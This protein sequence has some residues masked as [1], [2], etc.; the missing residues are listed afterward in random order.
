MKSI[1]ITIHI[2]L[3]S[4][5]AI[6]QTQPQSRWANPRYLETLPCKQVTDMLQDKDGFLWIATRNG[7]FRY[8][9][10]SL[11]PYRNDLRNVQYLSGNNIKCIAEQDQYIWIA[12]TAGLDR[13]SKSTSQSPTPAL[14]RREGESPA[15]TLSPSPA[16]PRREG[17][18]TGVELPEVA[19]MLVS[20]RG[21][22]WL[23]TEDGVFAYNPK[24]SNHFVPYDSA[25]TEGVIPT[26]LNAKCLLEDHLGHI[27]VGSW[28]QGLYRIDADHQLYYHYPDFNAGHNAHVLVE[29]NHKQIWIGTWGYGVE[30]LQNAWEPAITTARHYTTQ[31]G[32]SGNIIY[33]LSNDSENDII[34]VGTQRGL[35]EINETAFGLRNEAEASTKRPSAY[36]TAPSAYETLRYENKTT[37]QHIITSTQTPFNEI[38]CLLKDRQNQYWVGMMGLGAAHVNMQS[39]SFTL[40]RLPE[41]QKAINTADVRSLLV[42]H[43]GTL[44]LSVGTAG[45]GTIASDGRFTPWWNMPM[46]KGEPTMAT[47]YSLM[48]RSTDHHL[49]FATYG[50]YLY[51]VDVD[52]RR[53]TRH[54]PQTLRCM[55]RQHVNVISED[56]HG[57]LWFGGAGG[58][59]ILRTDGSQLLLDTLH[60][61]PQLTTGQ[62]E[63]RDII[64]D[65][66]NNTW[67]ATSKDGLFRLYAGRDGR[68][69]SDAFTRQNGRLLSASLQCLYSDSQGNIW[70]GTDNCG[71]FRY[72]YTTATFE[73]LNNRWSLPCV[74]V[75]SIIEEPAS[76]QDLPGR[77]H[78][79]LGTDNGLVLLDVASDAQSASVYHYTPDDGL[80]DYTFNAGSVTFDRATDEIFFGGLKGYNSFLPKEVQHDASQL[81]L[82][83]T[84][85]LVNDQSLDAHPD[86]HITL[87]HQQNNFALQFTA[88]DLV[89]PQRQSYI[90]QLQGY[91]TLWHYTDA[92][93]RRAHYSA[94]PAGTYTF[95]CQLSNSPESRTQLQI[96]ILPAP[97]RTWWAYTA[98][99]LF[100]L[101]VIAWII[102]YVRRKQTIQRS[103]RQRVHERQRQIELL[104]QQARQQQEANQLLLARNTMHEETQIVALPDADQQFLSRAIA[105]VNAHLS[106]ADF[107]QQQFLDEMGISKTTCFRRLKTLTGYSFP[108]FVRNIRMDAAAQALQANPTLRISEL[109]YSVGYTDAGYF[110]ACFRKEFGVLPTDYAKNL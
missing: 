55:P 30:C 39:S 63:V 27:W 33:S 52:A 3:L 97:W 32:L 40:N 66:Y 37:K 103:L 70:L 85:L 29:D 86:G 108:N 4:L 65:R 54:T 64:E 6:A 89:N 42:D 69:H 31:Q 11:T 15:Q 58:L 78:L 20:R 88:L 57:C 110:S 87:T 34:L 73:S 48:Q 67:I 82:H 68:W 62:V 9:G 2:F 10:A 49:W 44:W 1:I 71:L 50:E 109:A 51:E 75:V 53:L 90:Y 13:I 96:T 84:D 43:R 47:A 76:P 72:N 17:V 19:D 102:W 101:G 7:L 106:D 28:D 80:Q 56:H 25:H 22:L 79:W 38:T 81:K 41:A 100:V 23:A 46:F 92:N 16:L 91:D 98:Y 8:D 26:H 94:L 21:T 83:I 18:N 99:A 5:M 35:D 45:I 107:S 74:A 14:P 59:G 12:T 36:E 93:I 61:T 24:E 104:Q 60:L 77:T 95:V 105:C